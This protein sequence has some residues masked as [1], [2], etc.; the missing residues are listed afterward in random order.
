MRTTFALVLTS[1]AVTLQTL[2]CAEGDGTTS[3]VSTPD[4]SANTKDGAVQDAAADSSPP[5]ADSSSPDA[6]TDTSVDSP[7]TSDSSVVD[8]ATSDG[9]ADSSSP[10]A[11]P[12]DSSAPETAV[13]SAVD[14]SPPSSIHIS[15]IFVALAMQGNMEEWVEISAPPE[16]KLDGLMLRH[17]RWE[18]A[19]KPTVAVFDLPIADS[20][21]KMP[22]KGLWVVGGAMA[23][24]TDKFYLASDNFG[25]ADSAGSL[26][27]YRN[28][29][30]ELLD[31][32]GY[33]L[34][35]PAQAPEAPY[36]T[37]F[38]SPAPL[39]AEGTTDRST[40]RRSVSAPA[41]NALD[42]CLQIP[43]P[44]SSNASCL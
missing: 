36:T 6:S 37:M 39:G 5:D 33:G 35:Q 3:S 41:N 29:T 23:N 28:S 38:L 24:N 1:L 17:Y 4:A 11:S 18:S 8:S 42:F 20:G 15:E 14:A 13:D 22:A 34:A 7:T 26:Q 2:G 25:L 44:G 40:G 27:L 43:T 9:S 10:D 31:A 12:V 16:T 19:S 32:V 30:K 21:E